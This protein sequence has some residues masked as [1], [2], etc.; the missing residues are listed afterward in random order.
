MGTMIYFFPQM[1]TMIL[2]DLD[3]TIRNMKEVAVKLSEQIKGKIVMLILDM[4]G[5]VELVQAVV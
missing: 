2:G 5:G 4:Q 3:R 1:G